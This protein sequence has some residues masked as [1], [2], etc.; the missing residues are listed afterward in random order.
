[1]C[2]R[3]GLYDVNEFSGRFNTVPPE[4]DV[5]RPNWNA[6][7]GQFMPV[8][9]AGTESGG[10]RQIELM[11]W[12]LVP[13]W[14]KDAGIGYKMIKPAW[15][16]PIR[17]HRCLIPANGFYEWRHEAGK[18]TKQPYFIHPADQPLFA[19]AGIYSIWKTPDGETMPTY[20]I[21]TTSPNAE[22]T[23]IHDRMP[24]ILHPETEGFWLDPAV[25]D[26]GL[27]AELLQPYPDHKL[28]LYEVSPDVN[29]VRNND[30][31]LIEPI[32]SQ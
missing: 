21:M 22:M 17:H 28:E 24:V 8:V 32:N 23:A 4:P 15:R 6:A 2:G 1:M 29:F 10:E 26:R 25:D 31:R 3:Y 18:K 11:K 30:G 14:A 20:S 9:T 7:P 27:L 16:E 13:F 19:F 12:G 5:L